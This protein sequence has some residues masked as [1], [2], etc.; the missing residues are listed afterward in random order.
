MTI[1]LIKSMEFVKLTVIK[2]VRYIFYLT[3]KNGE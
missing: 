2:Y 1:I 3:C